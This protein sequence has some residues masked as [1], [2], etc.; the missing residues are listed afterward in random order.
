[1]SVAELLAVLFPQFAPLQVD[2]IRPAGRSIRV[3]ARGRIP[4][5]ACPGC[6]IWSDRVHSGYERRISDA[7][8][9]GQELV[10]HLR[11]RR[12]FCDSA[13]CG[14]QTFAEQIPGLTFRYGR[15]TVPLRKAREAVA[16]A[17]GGRAGA[18]LTEHLAA[19]IGRDALIRLVRALPDPPAGPVRVL[20]V[21]DFALR[22]GHN[23]GTVLIDIEG[24]RPVDVLP[25]RS[26]DALADW[27]TEHPGVEVIC[28]GRARYYADGADRGAATAIQ[29]ADR[30]HLWK[31]LGEAAERLVARL[32]SQWIP[33][34][35][36]KAEVVLPE[37]LRAQRTRERHAAVHALMNKGVS[38]SRIVAELRLDPKTV[39]KF[40]RAATPEERIGARPTGR[41]S[42]LDSHAAYL[43]ARFNEGCTSAD[44]L[45]RELAE[46]GLTV[47]E[48]TV[49][50]FV[51]RLRDNAKPTACPAVPKVREVT[52]LI[53]T[54]PDNRPKDGRVILKE[55]RDRCLDLDAACEL[56]TRFASILVNR[57]GQEELEQW[58]ADAEASILPELRGF[59]IGLRKDWDAVLAGL[60]LRWNSGP[61]KGHVNRIKMIKRQM[62]GRA[63]LDLLRKRVLL[64][65]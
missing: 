37:G 60:T 62:F 54:H 2:L 48:R 29:V 38:H 65:S 3:H 27:L 17:L 57:R 19:G 36:Q 45:H 42:S 31:N 14:K 28:R 52:T 18:R 22:K 26:A 39:R 58:T 40:M 43:I 32:R 55:L 64:A 11:V 56:I 20:G 10:L 61:V 7:A 12:F 9:S 30:F 25:E 24:R 53:L 49:R 46:R 8:V 23:Y 47:S 21:D 50:R 35:P 59:A 44:R 13:E 6:G 15:C 5:A 63:K 51:H 33:P 1:M 41:Q 34:A 16:L 4:R